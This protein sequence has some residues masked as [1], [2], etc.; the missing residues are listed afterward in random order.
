MVQGVESIRQELWGDEVSHQVSRECRAPV[1][2]EA[3]TGL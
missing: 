2:E 1:H 3:F